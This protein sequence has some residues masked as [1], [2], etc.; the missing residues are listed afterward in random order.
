MERLALYFLTTHHGHVLQRNGGDGGVDG[1]VALDHVNRFPQDRVVRLERRN[2]LIPA[3]E[4]E[5]SALAAITLSL[6]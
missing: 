1:L 5:V 2:A 3:I 6:P 4:H